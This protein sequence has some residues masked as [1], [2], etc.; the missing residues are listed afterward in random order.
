MSE[1]K[2]PPKFNFAPDFTSAQS[3]AGEM[4]HFT[5]SETR[6]LATLTQASNRLVTRERLLDALSGEGSDRNDRT[7]DF[8]IN[9]LRRKLSD[10]AR[11]PRYIATRYGEGYIWIA[12]IAPSA[13]DFNEA[14]TIVGPVN[15]LHLLGDKR[16]QGELLA[17]D[18]LR[19]V[20]S[21]LSPEYSVVY[22]ADCPPAHSF[23]AGGPK[24]SV[25]LAFFLDGD[26]VNCIAAAKEFR[27]GFILAMQRVT[28]TDTDKPISE[29]HSVTERLVSSLLNEAWRT[30]ATRPEAD[31][32]LPVAMAAATTRE[33]TDPSRHTDSDRELL[34]MIEQSQRR[35]LDA[36]SQTD[37][38]I[39]DL[40]NAEPDNPQLKIIHGIHIHTKYVTLGMKLFADGIDNRVRDEATIETLTLEALP[41][42]QADPEYAI[43]AA[44]LLHFV[45]HGYADLASVLAEE[46][47][48]SSVSVARS[49][50]VIGQLRAFAGDTDGA[51]QCIEPSLNLVKPGSQA[52]LYAMIIKCQA[53]LAAGRCEELLSAKKE[54][55]GVSPALGLFLEPLFTDP[56][57][58]SF[59]AKAAL[60][61][62]NR[63]RATALLLH[64]HYVSSRLFAAQEHRENSIRAPLTLI[65]RRFGTEA[66]PWEVVNAYPGLVRDIG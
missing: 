40:R 39:T 11:N 35:N 41:Y 44:K 24:Q 63:T 27:S 19:A 45:D 58:P 47:Y 30:L 21:E 55:Y 38:R 3:E 37:R 52:Y 66:L 17:R 7:V 57:K 61:A 31:G 28:L 50:V 14:H 51:L 10:S 13:A 64:K 32:P 36:W 2:R 20:R 16:S 43:M 9:R 8:L 5:R 25:E 29:I 48:R 34:N 60:L 42:V 12:D 4:L 46:A 1:L 15:G 6:A 53:L 23:V 18:I 65:A 59:R 56:D 49:L 33:N 22:A 62:L 26:V 54:L